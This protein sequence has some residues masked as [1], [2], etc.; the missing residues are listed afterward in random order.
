MLLFLRDRL[1]K[2]KFGPAHARRDFFTAG[3]F[4]LLQAEGI[5]QEKTGSRA[6]KIRISDANLKPDP[7]AAKDVVS[8]A[9]RAADF[10]FS[11]SPD[12]RETR[13]VWTCTRG[14]FRWTFDVN[15]TAVI[16]E[17]RV[18][19]RMDDGVLLDLKAGDLAFFPRGQK[20]V[21]TI[22]EN[23]RKVYVLYR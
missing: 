11:V 19:V 20:S 18:T 10:V 21:W 2:R 16:L 13:G 7:I 3:L 15:E 6:A 23:L 22:E 8:G 17:G 12:S 4:A 1:R 5:A 14:S 9:P